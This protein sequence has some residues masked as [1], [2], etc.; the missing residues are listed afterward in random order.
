MT[1]GRSAFADRVSS[2]VGV[3][4]E[5][6]LTGI[7]FLVTSRAAVLAQWMARTPPRIFNL[8]TL[9]TRSGHPGNGHSGGAAAELEGAF[10]ESV[11][12][13]PKPFSPAKRCKSL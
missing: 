10:H 3:D 2:T 7:D 1:I 13:A 4:S 5:Y 9:R 8:T 12:N 6:K 11:G